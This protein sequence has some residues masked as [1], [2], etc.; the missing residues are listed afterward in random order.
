MR[1][2][3]SSNSRFHD[4]LLMPLSSKNALSDVMMMNHYNKE[5][6]ACVTDL[7]SI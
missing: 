5:V 6:L 4:T 3:G 7:P 2:I 1:Q